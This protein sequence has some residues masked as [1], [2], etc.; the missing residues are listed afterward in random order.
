MRN[1]PI[2][3]AQPYRQPDPNT[4]IVYSADVNGVYRIPSKTSPRDV[5]NVIASDGLDWDHVSVSLRH[6]C[7]TWAEMEQVRSI[8]FRDD[9]TV[10]QLSVP[11]ADHISIHAYCLHLW[12]PQRAEIP[13]PPGY[14]VG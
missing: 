10:M 5:L 2:V 11:R 13:R 1:A 6:R 3:R 12:R 7:P 8:F 14:L 9:E 4:G